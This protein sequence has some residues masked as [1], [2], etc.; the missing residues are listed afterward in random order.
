[1][2]PD[3][4]AILL[5]TGMDAAFLELETAERLLVHDAENTAI[6]FA[7]NCLMIDARG[8]RDRPCRALL[9]AIRCARL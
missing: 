3:I 1:L 7:T 5:A 2:L 4:K 6:F 8:P 9:A